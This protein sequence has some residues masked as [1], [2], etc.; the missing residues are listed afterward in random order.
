M[1]KWSSFADTIIN[2]INLIFALIYNATECSGDFL[3]G[4][5]YKIE[6]ICYKRIKDKIKYEKRCDRLDVQYFFDGILYILGI[7]LNMG[8]WVAIASVGLY[9]IVS[10]ITKSLNKLLI[11]KLIIV[12]VVAIVCLFG[13]SFLGYFS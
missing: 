3:Y 8:S 7:I 12:L 11:K 2:H 5:I 4:N 9:F 1:N 13:S 10:L 6:F